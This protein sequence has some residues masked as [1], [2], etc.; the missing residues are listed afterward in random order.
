VKSAPVA[1]TQVITATGVGMALLYFLRSILI[2]VVVAFVLAILVD[3]LVRSI[4][5]RRPKT[6]GWAVAAI[7]GAIIGSSAFG[8]IYVIAQGG[9][10]IVQQGPALIARLEQLVEEAGRSLGLD[11]PLR[12]STLVGQ[13]SIP[14]LAG[15]VLASLQSVVSGVFLMIVYFGFMLAS[16]ARIA[17]KVRNIATTSDRADAIKK[18]MGRIAGDIETYVWVQTL[19]GMMLAGVSGAVMVGV[20]LDNALFWTIVLFLLSFIPVVGVTVGS[21][22]PALFALLQFPTVWQAA[23]VFGGIQVA[24]F[25]VGNLIYPRMQADT[26]NID[27][28]ATIL[29]LSFWSFLWGLPGAFLA[30]P[31]TLMLM[32]VCAQFENTRWVAVLLS[33]D[34][35]PHLSPRP[36]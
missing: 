21:V 3:A 5:R 25:V 4:V 26:Q 6:P 7:A 10:E 15:S 8:A 1:I 20:G 14:A 28:V 24:A 18:G 17:P 30:V 31:L 32:M 27:P 33:N 34:G 16:R 12:L 22:A 29:A 9:V 36:R 13:I 19:T 2:P 23:A 11:Q 35:R